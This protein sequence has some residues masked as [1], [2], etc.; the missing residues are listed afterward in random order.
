MLDLIIIGA[1]SAGISAYKE[2]RKYTDNLRIINDGAWDT[3]C[4]RVGCMPS[5][6][7]ISTANRLHDAHHADQVGL[8]LKIEAD[9]SQVMTHLQALR[10]HFTRSVI[11]DVD[12]WNTEHKISGQAKF[13]NAN[14]IEVN[15]EQLQAKSFILAVGSTPRFDQDDQKALGDRLIS[16]DD[17][18]ELPDLPKRL[19][20]IGSG[21]IAIELSQAMHNLG[22][23]VTTFARSRHAGILSSNNLQNIE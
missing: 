22:V 6:I 14:T 12:S 13:I 2:A 11:R 4:A 3:T 21:A 15:G 8:N 20:V 23:E 18:F 7:L 9:T 10:D 5:K 19:A 1:G 16:T 17:I